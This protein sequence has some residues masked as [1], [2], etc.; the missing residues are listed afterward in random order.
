MLAV[1]FDKDRG[2]NGSISVASA[3]MFASPAPFSEREISKAE[4]P[5]FMKSLILDV[6]S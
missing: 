3:M 6:A 4:R 2:G 5:K 1:I